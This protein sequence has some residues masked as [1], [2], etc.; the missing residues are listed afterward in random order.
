MTATAIR[1][2]ESA[3][4]PANAVHS[5]ILPAGEPWLHEVKQGQTLRIVDLEGNQAAD[6]IFYNRHDTDEHY[7]AT[8]T[9]LHQGGIYLTTGSVLMSSERPADAGPSSPTPAAATTRWAAPA[10]PRATP[11][12]TPCTRS[13]CTAAATTTCWPWQ[14]ADSGLTK[15]DLVPNVNFFMNVPVTPKAAEVRRRRFRPG[16]YVE[17]RAEMDLGA[18]LQLPAAQQPLQRLQP[19]A[20][21]VPVVGLIPHAHFR[22][23]PAGTTRA[24]RKDQAPCGTTRRPFQAKMRDPRGESCS[25]KSSSPTAAPS[26][27]A[28]IRTLKRWASP[29]SR[30]IPRPTPTRCMCWPT[31]PICI[32][33]ARRRRAICGRQD[34]RSRP[35]HRRPG[36]PPGLRLPLREPRLRRCLRGGRHRLH[37]PHP[38]QMRAFG[39]K[40]T[41]RELAEQAGVPLLPGSGLLADA[42]T[43]GGS[44]AH[45]LPGDAEEHRRRR[46][47]RHA[48]DLERGELDEAYASVDRLA[49]AN[50][51]EAGI[52][53]EKY[54]EQ[55]R[56]IEVQIFGDGQGRVARPGRA[57]LLGAA[58]QPE[59]H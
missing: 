43:P 14:H 52:Y 29:R 39:L 40:H 33:P 32:G 20:G 25:A 46:R 15:R 31:R 16:K 27:A 24:D 19:D 13:T 1:I 36:D 7:S 42:A 23:S 26:P 9:M 18:G 2:Q 35:R 41:A 47:H 28:S 5:A 10:P 44:G 55:A 6:V 59:S 48:P 54:V 12:A 37:R 21:A 49:R 30:C 4:D 17:L 3:L 34:P 50:F 56:H 58:P 22:H 53:L 38:A 57:R 51:K 8:D 45:R 11:C